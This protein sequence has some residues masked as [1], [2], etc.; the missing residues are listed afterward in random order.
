V[1]A[2]SVKKFS[3][4]RCSCAGTVVTCIQTEAVFHSII[5]PGPSI[6]SRFDGGCR[7][8]RMFALRDA[9]LLLIGF[10]GQKQQRYICS[11]D[12]T[13]RCDCYFRPHPR[14][15]AS[16]A[17][18]ICFY[19]YFPKFT[20][21]LGVNNPTTMKIRVTAWGKISQILVQMVILG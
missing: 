2:A 16:K 12:W 1:S 17:A 3:Q 18:F 8:S 9:R 4:G 6:N 10:G 19:I 11:V 5:G 14:K 13:C 21:E 15:P 7:M 20:A